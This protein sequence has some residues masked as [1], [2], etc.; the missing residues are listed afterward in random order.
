M[1]DLGLIVNL[2]KPEAINMAKKLI[3]WGNENNCP[4]LL[5]HQEASALTTIGLDD[6]VWLR[7]V[8]L[9]LVIGGDGT[10]L[11]AA[12]YVMGTE[13]I[14]HGVNMGHLGFLASTKPDEIQ[15]DLDNI[16]NDNFEI[17]ERR[18]LK[19][20]LY[21]DDQ[22]TH[23]IYA[24]NDIVLTTNAIARLVQI[25]IK[26]ND[27][28]F[29]VLPADGVIISTPTGSTAYA[30]SAGGSI[31]PPQMDAMILAPLC[32]HTLYSRPLIASDRDVITLI[33]RGFSRDL[34]LT[35]DGQVAYEIF[36]NDRIEIN[37]SKSRKI[38]TINLPGKN[39]LDIVSEKLG[40]G[41]AFNSD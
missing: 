40:W 32:A 25:E 9:A 3:D 4:F 22:I 39:F 8:K 33:P 5:P 23:K 16:I 26:F 17:V 35:Q 6:E 30:L 11:R 37:L 31:I 13:I 36:P 1:K 14:L 41:Q 7:T 2:R 18:V 38:R 29:C 19:S 28:F 20:V 27:K 21:H 34:M 12:R 10:F 15:H 24:L